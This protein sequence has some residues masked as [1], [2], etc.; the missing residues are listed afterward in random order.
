MAVDLQSRQREQEQEG[1]QDLRLTSN[2]TVFEVIYRKFGK[3][4]FDVMGAFVLLILLSVPMLVIALLVK[5]SSDGPALFRQTRF[6]LNTRP[7]ILVKFRSMTVDAPEKANKDFKTE[8]RNSYITS[9]GHFLR[10]TSLDELP[11][12]INILKGEMSFIGPRPLA[13]TDSFV[14]HSRRL[15]GADTVRP[16]IT[17]LAQVNGRNLI[18][19]EMK[20]ELDAEYADHCC[21]TLD[22][23][24]L[25]RSFLVVILQRGIDKK[26]K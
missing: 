21:F 13:E 3:R 18:S 23:S 6:G 17:G 26:T 8:E 5:I 7:F 2:A 20:A 4:L 10:K 22:V 9:L 15:S 11:Q 12:L 16:E 14:V 19:D 25:L 24:I 1:E